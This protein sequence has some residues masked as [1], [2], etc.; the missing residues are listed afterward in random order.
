MIIIDG[1]MGEGGGQI[2]RSALSLSL[3]TGKPFTIARIR[4]ARPKPGLRPQHLAAVSAAARISHAQ[5]EGDRV[6]SQWLSFAPGVIAPG[7]YHFDIGTAGATTL[8]LQTVL[9]PLALA[10]AGSRLTISGGTHVPWSPSFHYLDLH[11]RHFLAR[12]GIDFG[13]T[14]QRAGFYPHGGG[15]LL[16]TLPGAAHPRPLQLVRRGALRRIR[17][18]SAVANLP[19]TIAERQRTQALRRLRQLA[20]QVA[21]EIAIDTL[22]AISPGTM[23]L[24]LAEFEASQAC[25][26]ALGERGK[27]AE[28]VAD[29]A[30]DALAAFLGSDGA[31]EPW[32]ADQLLLPL[33]LAP[34]CSTLRTSAVTQHLLTNA[35]IIRR[36]LPVTIA[37]EATLGAPATVTISGTAS[38]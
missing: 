7:S 2:V 38:L 4:A 33:A 26:T 16:A 37:V 35:A 30:A 36:F 28:R 3:L 5:V 32:L 25:F 11:W 1:A 29:E 24:L 19:L 14:L 15:E 18:V 9:L 23:L 34:G 17:G 20:P 27:P 22:A 13:L 6:G 10:A 21:T 31:V 12:I 8:V